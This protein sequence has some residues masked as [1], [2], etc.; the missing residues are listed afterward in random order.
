MKCGIKM[1]KI[2]LNQSPTSYEPGP[3]TFSLFSSLNLGSFLTKLPPGADDDFISYFPGPGFVR[4][5]ALTVTSRGFEKRFVEERKPPFFFE[6]GFS[7]R[8]DGYRTR[9]ESEVITKLQSNLIQRIHLNSLM[10]CLIVSNFSRHQI[11]IIEVN[12]VW[13]YNLATAIVLL[14][15]L[16]RIFKGAKLSSGLMGC[17]NEAF[18]DYCYRPIKHPQPHL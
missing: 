2:G 17:H 5:A 4:S 6:D 12:Y 8:H 7:K 10:C 15:D 16:P 18:I 13:D 9:P 11:P 14:I 1:E 3:G